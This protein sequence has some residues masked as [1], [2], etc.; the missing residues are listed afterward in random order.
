[1]LRDVNYGRYTIETGLIFRESIFLSKILLN[2]EVWHSITKSQIEDLEMIDRIL[3]RNILNAH[4]KTGLEWIYAEGGKLSLKCIIQIRRLMYLWHV[5]H[6]DKTELISR[7]YLTQK[8]Q[9]SVGD[10]VR[11]VEADKSELGINLTDQEI[12]GVTKMFLKIM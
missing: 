6:R 10:W 9:N 5:L 7:I 8:N 12:Q 3:L 11:L 2:S 1:M 4:S